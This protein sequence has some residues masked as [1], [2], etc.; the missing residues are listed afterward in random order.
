[1]EESSLMMPVLVVVVSADADSWIV[2]FDS[3]GLLYTKVS[4]CVCAGVSPTFSI[5]IVIGPDSENMTFECLF[6]PQIKH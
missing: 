6:P 5:L 2:P 1:V 3:S 4:N